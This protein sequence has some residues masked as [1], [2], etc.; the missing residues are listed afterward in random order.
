MRSQYHLILPNELNH[1]GT[2]FGGAAMAAADKAAFIEATLNF[3]SAEFVTKTFSE[4]NF[5][6]PAK[7]GDILEILTEVTHKGNSSVKISILA[8]NAKTQEQIFQTEA[9]MV[10]APNGK[11]APIQDAYNPAKPLIADYTNWRGETR[12]RS[13]LPRSLR[14][15]ATEW[16]K[17]PQWLLKAMDTESKEEREFTLKDFK[18][19]AK[20]TS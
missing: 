18:F 2:L 1:N 16:H 8:R 10:N 17:E 14:Y 9:V 7:Q 6:H 13:I 4:F 5:L 15:G 11:S 19:P 20:H 12:Q 3:P